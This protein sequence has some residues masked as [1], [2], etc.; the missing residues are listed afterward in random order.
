MSE[1]SPSM[2]VEVNTPDG[3]LYYT[4]CEDGDNS[5]I[6]VISTFGKAG[7]T[8]AAWAYAVDV[9]TNMLLERGTKIDSLIEGLSQISASKPLRTLEGIKVG[10]GPEGLVVALLEYKRQKYRELRRTFEEIE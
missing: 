10:S 2:T 4:I 6:R 9:L 1:K 5:P 7:T 3:V 8:L